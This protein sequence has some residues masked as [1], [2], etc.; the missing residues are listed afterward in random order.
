MKI[1]DDILHT[2]IKEFFSM[3]TYK[4]LH[5]MIDLAWTWEIELEL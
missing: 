2:N 5:E 3:N 4:T 1:A